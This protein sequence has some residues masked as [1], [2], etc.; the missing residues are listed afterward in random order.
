MAKEAPWV[1]TAEVADSLVRAGIISNPNNVKRV[2]ITVDSAEITT[3]EV[4]EFATPNT[5]ATFV[6][7]I[8]TEFQLVRKEGTSRE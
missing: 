6:D 1:T 2:V 8:T 7:E 5:V 3:V 4:T